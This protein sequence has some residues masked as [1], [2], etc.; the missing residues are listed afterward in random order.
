VTALRL[1]LVGYGFGGRWFHSP[2]IASAPGVELAGVVTRSAERRAELAA[3]HPGTPAYDSLGAMADAGVDAVAISTPVATHVPLIREAV[4]LGLPVVCDKPFAPDAAGA[5]EAVE[6]AEAAGVALTVYQNRRWDSEILTLGKL[7]AEG[8]LGE[9][10]RFESRFEV[11]APGTDFGVAG[12]GVRLDLGSHLTDQALGLFGPVESVYAE[13]RFPEGRPEQENHFF[14]SLRH[15]SGVTSQ[16][17]ASADQP[18]PGPR[19]RVTGTRA[20]YVNEHD[21]GQGGAVLAGRTPASEGD[22]W[23]VE[24]ESRW[25]WLHDGSAREPVPSERGR[26]D[27]FYPAFAAA[28]R[29][30]G[31]PPVDPRDAVETMEVLDAART[32]AETGA[33][34]QLE[35]G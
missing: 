5:R 33:V 24:P 21:D 23:G 20:A 29:G 17:W 2:L 3:D 18:A 25:G 1:G 32:S 27:T 9:V 22:A 16:L 31:P 26:W 10:T 4:A 7:L 8:R 14:A 12:G 28:V 30:D 11:F 13:T 19:L 6:A 15:R 34:V 35:E